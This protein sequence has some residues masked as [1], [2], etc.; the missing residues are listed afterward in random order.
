MMLGIQ[1]SA[2]NQAAG[3]AVRALLAR[4]PTTAPAPAP[5]VTPAPAPGLTAPPGPAPDPAV[6][7]KKAED[8][9]KAGPYKSDVTPGGAG[10]EGGF[11]A[12][13]N[14]SK[15]EMTIAMRCAVTFKHGIDDALTPGDPALTPVVTKAKRLRGAARK[16]FIA[17]YQ[18]TPE[19][20]GPWKTDLKALIDEKWGKK[21]E[22]HLRKPQWEWIGAKVIVNIDVHDGP[23]A[24]NDHMAID[25]IKFPEGQ[26]LYSFNEEAENQ[27]AHN[28]GFSSTAPGA[29]ADAHD[30]TM[31]LA[32]TDIKARPDFN[33]LRRS[34][35]FAIGKSELTPAAK[36]ELDN[37]AKTF[38]GKV[39]DKRSINQTVNLE[40]HASSS[41]TAE[42]NMALATERVTAVSDYLGTHGFTNVAARATANP[43]GAA[44]A[45]KG[46]DKRDRRVDL[47]VGD[48]SPQI[49]AVHEFG[50]AFGLDDEYA[51]TALYG[52]SGKAV[53]D[54]VGHDEQTKKMQDA[55]GNKLP[56]A[57]SETSDSIMSAGNVIRPQHYSTFHAALSSVTHETA[58]AL[59]PPEPKPGV[60]GAA[61][62][63]APA[64]VP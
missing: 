30:Q 45:H 35:S 7:L 9:V 36:S 1:R 37:W 53:G 5:G 8:F 62:A 18:W 40:G 47:V 29:A 42:R 52:G 20:K 59:G 61:P 49:L 24:A 39:G 48:G 21:H 57:I 63:P 51:D 27:A 43:K 33:V 31:T 23:K 34:V 55:G 28:K 2:G 26:N 16:R 56:G 32:S 10:T 3:L 60:P 41:G 54:A 46:E 4:Q 17:P 15:G 50:H 11:E 19:Q 22:F 13:Y 58:W 6:E 12:D 25:T 38:E 44:D 14:P 64:P